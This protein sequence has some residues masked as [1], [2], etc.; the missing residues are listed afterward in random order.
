MEKNCGLQSN[1][2]WVNNA[3]Y[4]NNIATDLAPGESGLFEIKGI[5]YDS[6]EKRRVVTGRS[7]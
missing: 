2:T 4:S 5:Q 6:F 7:D 3:G 1:K